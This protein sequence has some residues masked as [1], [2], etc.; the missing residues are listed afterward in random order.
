M[1]ATRAGLVPLTLSGKH[2]ERLA[3]LAGVALPVQARCNGAA[4][5][6]FFCSQTRRKSQRSPVA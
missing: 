1:L 5:R 2:S 6:N 4:F 3:D